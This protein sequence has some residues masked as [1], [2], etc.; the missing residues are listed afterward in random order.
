MDKCGFCPA[1]TAPRTPTKKIPTQIRKVIYSPVQRINKDGNVVVFFPEG[2]ETA[3]EKVVC[4]NCASTP[5]PPK[6]VGEKTIY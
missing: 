4:P 5:K 1:V 3:E 2:W 6:V